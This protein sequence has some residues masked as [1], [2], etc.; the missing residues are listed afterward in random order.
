[1]LERAHPKTASML[2]DAKN[3]LL[4]FMN[5]PAEHWRQIWSTNPL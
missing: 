4:A 5:F 1:M 3:D 2:I